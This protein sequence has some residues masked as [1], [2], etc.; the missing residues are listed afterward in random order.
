MPP[1]LPRRPT[2]QPSFVT[3]TLGRTDTTF[4]DFS[5][6]TTGSN[7]YVSQT[8]NGEVILDPTAGREFAGTSDAEPVDRRRCGRRAARQRSA[9]G[10]VTLD[11]AR[12]GTN[13]A[14]RLGTDGG[15][16]GDL[17]RAGRSECGLRHGLQQPPP[18]RP[19]GRTTGGG[20]YA[21]SSVFDDQSSRTRSSRGA[22]WARLTSSGSIGAPRRS[23]S[24]STGCRSPSTRGRSGSNMRPLASDRTHGSGN[25]VVDWMRMTPVLRVGNLHIARAR[26]GV[27]AALEHGQLAL[28]PPRGNH[29]GRERANRQHTEPGRPGRTSF[30]PITVVRRVRSNRP[31]LDISNIA[32]R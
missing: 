29:D 14:V 25:L 19:S 17:Q 21:R 31:R 20:L 32:S 22:G 16:R 5:G 9:Q 8:Q 27:D 15:V 2:R 23:R 1:C 26:C 12:V 7:T 6:G 13:N 28:G 3:P 24:G 18:G 10:V 11:G 4:G 30:R